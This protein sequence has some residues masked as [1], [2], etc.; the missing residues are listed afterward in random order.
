MLMAGAEVEE[1]VVVELA[2]KMVGVWVEMIA[3]VAAD[4]VEC[5]AA[6]VL[7]LGLWVEL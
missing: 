6:V 3:T 2:V 4:T 5:F 1:E 7:L